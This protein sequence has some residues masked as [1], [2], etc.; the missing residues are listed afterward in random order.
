VVDVEEAHVGGGLGNAG[1]IRP[2][3]RGDRDGLGQ[4]N[5]GTDGKGAVGEQDGIAGT[6]SVNGLLDI[7]GGLA[8]GVEGGRM[9][10]RGGNING[11]SPNGSG[12]QSI[13]KKK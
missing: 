1:G 11:L 12:Q 10:P 4:G 2:V 8:P 9:R 3:E 6:R 13:R 7:G 5:F